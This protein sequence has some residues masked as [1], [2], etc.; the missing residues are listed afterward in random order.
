[1]TYQ[2]E[3]L[4]EEYKFQAFLKDLFNTIYDTN[5]FEEYGSKGHMQHGIDVY[6]PGLSI[7]VQAKKKDIHR[8]QNLI[9]RELLTELSD[10]LKQ[11]ES[12]PHPISRLY[13][14]TTTKKYMVIQNAC[15]KASRTHGINVIFFCWN[16]IQAKLA[17]C[18]HV[19]NQYFPHLKEAA[20]VENVLEEKIRRLE[21]L[22]AKFEPQNLKA[23]K[24]YRDIP[25]TDI[26]IPKMELKAQ[27]TLTAIMMRIALFQTFARTKYKK[28][29]C[30][31]NFSAS[32]TQFGDGTSAPGFEIICGEVQFL[33][34]C[35]RLIKLLQYEPDRFWEQFDHYKE[36]KDFSYI[37]FR[38][39]LLPVE[40]LTCYDI[41]VDVQT[42]HYEIK[43]KA[44]E[45][46]EY[47]K[48]DSLSAILP[49]IAHST[50][51]TINIIEFDKIEKHS[52]F[53]KLLHH[54]LREN[55]FKRSLLKVNVDDFDDWDFEYYP[56]EED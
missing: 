12:F 20:S 43:V 23:K 41:E 10:T 13:F 15:M 1:M 29:T 14:A 21:L 32:Y 56:N 37:K 27:Q 26:L 16:D 8:S 7:A 48:L 19:R 44:Y 40:G 45:G 2:Y 17:D 36:D 54:M 22:I 9:I 28:F 18:P 53:M 5:T 51:P 50:K 35:T 49:F 6:S 25:Y 31:F 47:H 30:L 33:A 24:Q 3:P 42:G 55:S 46:L 11:I 38:M 4:A 39:E 52:A 34:N